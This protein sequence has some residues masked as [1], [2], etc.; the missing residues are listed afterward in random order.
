VQMRSKRQRYYILVFGGFRRTNEDPVHRP[1][2]EH[3]TKQD[4]DNF[5]IPVKSESESSIAF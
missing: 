2:N 5:K 3:G 4:T 1:Q